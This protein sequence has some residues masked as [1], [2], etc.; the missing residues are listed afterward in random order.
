MTF[1]G[2]GN[3]N[4]AEFN[5]E[6]TNAFLLISEMAFGLNTSFSLCQKGVIGFVTDHH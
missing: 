6:K 2:D 4:I 1:H 3:Q 5:G